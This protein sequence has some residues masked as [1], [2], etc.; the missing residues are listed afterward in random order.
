MSTAFWLLLKYSPFAI[1]FGSP[2]PLIVLLVYTCFRRDTPRLLNPIRI[3]SLVYL[4][5]YIG[6]IFS[7]WHLIDVAINGMCGVLA[8]GSYCFLASTASEISS[9]LLRVAALFVLGAPVC[10]I[11]FF[12]YLSILFQDGPPYKT[13]QMRS[14]LICREGSYGM[15]GAGG[16]KI[17]L[18]ELWPSL[19]FIEKRVAGEMSDDAA[20]KADLSS[21][22]E[23][24]K[25]FE[26]R[27]GR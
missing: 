16:G 7:G 10:I 17:E 23:L 18:Y 26:D 25:K 5:V 15:V 11:T 12:G 2:V 9:R 27:N 14:D 3:A 24:L 4:I 8:I 6:F 19:P 1:F 22:A 13:E 21:C 20:P